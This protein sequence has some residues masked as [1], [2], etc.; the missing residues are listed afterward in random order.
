MPNKVPGKE[1][2]NTESIHII[3]DYVSTGKAVCPVQLDRML[4]KNLEKKSRMQ[5]FEIANQMRKYMYFIV[6]QM[7]NRN[8]DSFN[9]CEFQ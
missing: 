3:L 8:W 6:N 4:I 7:R 5:K 9:G 1:L 2:Y